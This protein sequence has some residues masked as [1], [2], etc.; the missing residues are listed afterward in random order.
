MPAFAVDQLLGALLVGTW[1]ASI[2]FGV[3]LVEA[4]KYFTLFPDDSW[5]RK[6]FVIFVLTVCIAALVWDYGTT[7]YPTVTY[8]GDVEALGTIFWTLPLSSFANTMLATI[9]DAYLIYRLYNLC[10]ENIWST[11]FLYALL[12]LAI[13]GYF[14]VFVLLV[15][16]RNIAER[17]TETIG[18]IIN[19]K[20]CRRMQTGYE[21]TVL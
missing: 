12:I 20:I 6:G 10:D 1:V 9:V 15:T 21:S 17:S 4:Y 16:R 19:L 5:M 18:D 11:L 13:G 3:V 14:V 8:W 2:L 7:Y